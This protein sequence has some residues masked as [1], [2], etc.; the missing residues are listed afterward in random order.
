[1]S[2]LA[3][4][5]VTARSRRVLDRAGRGP[6]GENGRQVHSHEFDVLAARFDLESLSRIVDNMDQKAVMIGRSV[7]PDQGPLAALR[8]AAGRL[9]G[10][11]SFYVTHFVG[12]SVRRAA[13]LKKAFAHPADSANVG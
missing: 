6:F 10:N 11:L 12:G 5:G 1:L 9:S 2:P 13:G 3:C 7:E 4:A 8:S